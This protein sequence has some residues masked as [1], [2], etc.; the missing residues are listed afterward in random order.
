MHPFFHTYPLSNESDGIQAPNDTHEEFDQFYCSALNLLNQFN[1]ENT[2]T[3]T[4]RDPEFVTP[5]LKHHCA[6]KT[7]SLDS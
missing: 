4:S 1:P 6:G 3:V 2:V 5:P 7:D